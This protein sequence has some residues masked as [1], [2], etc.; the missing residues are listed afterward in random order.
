MIDNIDFKNGFVLKDVI[1]FLTN[2]N[3]QLL[4]LLVTLLIFLFI[5]F[6]VREQCNCRI[7]DPVMRPCLNTQSCSDILIL[8]VCKNQQNR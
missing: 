3:G 2:H 5:P 1:L 6:Q 4:I 8:I 7:N